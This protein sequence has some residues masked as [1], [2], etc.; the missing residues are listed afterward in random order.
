MVKVT[1]SPK[2]AA[3][4]VAILSGF[5]FIFF[6][7]SMTAIIKPPNIMLANEAVDILPDTMTNPFLISHV[8]SV[9]NFRAKAPTDAKK[10]TIMDCAFY[11]NIKIVF[12]ISLN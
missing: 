6:D 3:I 5:I 10:P 11:I 7:T 9:I 8:S 12:N 1:K 2:E 4:G